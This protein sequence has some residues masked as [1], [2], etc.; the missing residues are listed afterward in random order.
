MN[1]PVSSDT[2]TILNAQGLV[3]YLIRDP[4]RENAAA[5]LCP[6]LETQP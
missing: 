3:K 1:V 6:L 2:P 5:A 4:V